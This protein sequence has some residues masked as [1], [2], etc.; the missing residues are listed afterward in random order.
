MIK[1]KKIISLV[2]K[3]AIALI[4]FLT[5]ILFLYTA[6]F[7]KKPIVE[8]KTE[9]KQII[10]EKKI[11]ETKEQIKTNKEVQ[12]KIKI[13]KIETVI[14]DRLFAT[15]GNKAITTSDIV[16]EIKIILI[17]NNIPYTDDKKEQLKQKAVQEII[18]RTIKKIEIDKNNFLDFNQN[19]F[20][21]E[22]NSLANR[23][24]IDLPTLKKICSDNNLDFS[25][26]ENQIKTELLW[27]SLIFYLYKNR[28]S[29]NLEEIDEQLK[30]NQNKK[31]F[32]EYLISELV[33]KSK[34]NDKLQSQLEEIK[35]KIE[36]EGFE[37]VAMNLSISNTAMK[38]G[39]LDWV[40]ENVI[41]EKFKSKIINTSI[42]NISEP[43]IL[44]EGILFFKVRDK[45]KLKKFLDL[46]DAKNQ[47]V[48]AEKTK[49]LRMHSLSHY[50]NLRKLITIKY[51]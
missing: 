27:N 3:S 13:K 23:I 25:I 46:E 18:K 36:I 17:I 20:K 1:I 38:G 5:L 41:S 15:V 9:E 29:I 11:E 49:V 8:K 30:L 6:F 21:K 4:I 12:E 37:N 32:E 44:P 2:I 31:E 34:G 14:K 10:K 22:L 47:L 35:R 48:R 28:V 40:S 33:V 51:Y 39:S 50:E 26:I 16:N 24:N 19:D 45:R 43:I 7:Y 42:G